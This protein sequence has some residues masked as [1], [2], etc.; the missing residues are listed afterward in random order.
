MD[1]GPE[2]CFGRLQTD[3]QELFCGRGFD[4]LARVDKG[5]TSSGVKLVNLP[6][7]LYDVAAGFP[8]YRT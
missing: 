7:H 6:E 5:L 3:A 2:S 8:P 1:T 4:G